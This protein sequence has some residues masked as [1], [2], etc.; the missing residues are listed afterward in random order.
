[1]PQKIV[2][3]TQVLM[4]RKEVTITAD[5][6]SLITVATT[7][8]LRIAQMKEEMAAL[9]PQ[10]AVMKTPE[11]PEKIKHVMI[12]ETQVIL[13][14][15]EMLQKVETKLA[16][17]QEILEIPEILVMPQKVVTKRA[18][19][20]E[21]LAILEI[22]V[23]DH[24]AVMMLAKIQV[25]MHQKAEMME[26]I[27]MMIGSITGLGM[28]IVDVNLHKHLQYLKHLQKTFQNVQLPL[29]LLKNV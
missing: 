24:L 12:L 7:Q 11:I 3:M 29:L 26:E 6:M 2:K 9:M 25:Q 20:L 21:T 28:M 13:E 16:M 1:V 22:L 10:K 8:V 17:I 23:M 15:L 19:I 14:I 5:Q 4:L 27:A 18:M